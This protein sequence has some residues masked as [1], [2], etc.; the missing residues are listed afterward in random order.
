MNYEAVVKAG[1]A[2]GTSVLT[3]ILLFA[4]ED[5]SIA[6]A[7]TANGSS[8]GVGVGVALLVI[9]LIAGAI[10]SVWF[11]RRKHLRS[12]PPSA[13][14]FENPSYI[15]EPNPDPTHVNGDLSLNGNGPNG[16]VSSLSMSNGLVANGWHSET[17]H[18]PRPETEVA[19]TLYEELRLG[20][21]GAGFRRL[22]S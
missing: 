11:Y 5:N 4:T 17:L 3:N 15:R 19:P 1:N 16:T 10:G 21:E 14:A 12:K 8:A 7:S 13:I 20:S 2:H 9:V 18:T 22:K 6:Y